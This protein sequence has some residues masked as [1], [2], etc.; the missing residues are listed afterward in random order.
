MGH[1]FNLV[2]NFAIVLIFCKK[3]VPMLCFDLAKFDLLTS[4]PPVFE[5]SVR[6]LYAQ[7]PVFIHL[8]HY[9]EPFMQTN[10]AELINKQKIN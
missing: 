2:S 3:I 4:S 5:A 9:A 8:F 6:K 10:V 7:R 1:P